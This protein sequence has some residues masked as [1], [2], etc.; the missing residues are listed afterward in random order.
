MIGKMVDGILVGGYKIVYLL[1]VNV[2]KISL[3]IIVDK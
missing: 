3:W 1:I 2:I